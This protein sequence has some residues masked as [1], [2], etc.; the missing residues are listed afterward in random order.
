MSVYDVACVGLAGVDVILDGLEV[1]PAS[2]ELAHAPRSEVAPG[3]SCNVAIASSRLG[4]RS[5]LVAPVCQDDLGSLLAARLAGAGVDWVG[6]PGIRTPLRVALATSG[7]R[8][9]VQAGDP[10]PRSGS[11]RPRPRSDARGARRRDVPARCR[12]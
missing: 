10:R 6:P 11:P 8:A 12:R 5:V 1:L 2:G 9:F 7:E 3:G 4:L